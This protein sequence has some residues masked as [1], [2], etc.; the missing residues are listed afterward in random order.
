M[1]DDRASRKRREAE[2]RQALR[3]ET[4]PLRDEVRRLEQA[5]TAAEGEVA[6]LTRRLSDPA[7]YDDPERAREMAEAHGRA[8]DRAAALMDAWEERQAALEEA[9][10]RVHERFGA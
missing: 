10:S 4:G 7:V 9:E 2:L 6:E 5:V 3:R 1:R 8:K